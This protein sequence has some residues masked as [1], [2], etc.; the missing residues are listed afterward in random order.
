VYWLIFYS[1]TDIPGSIR[2]SSKKEIFDATKAM[3][4]GKP[5]ASDNITA[6]VQIHMQLTPLTQ[7]IRVNRTVKSDHRLNG[8]HINTSSHF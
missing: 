8:K 5:A 1:I 2:P 4:I 3:N 6:N 7:K